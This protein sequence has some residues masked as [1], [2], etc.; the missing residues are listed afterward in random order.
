MLIDLHVIGKDKQR[1]WR[2]IVN[3]FLPII[4]DKRYVLDDK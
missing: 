3:I 2:K 1:V 4:F